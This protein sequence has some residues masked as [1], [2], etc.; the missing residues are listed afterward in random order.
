M[1]LTLEEEF[2]SLNMI[3]FHQYGESFSNDL[4]IAHDSVWAWVRL[5]LTMCTIPTDSLLG[6]TPPSVPSEPPWG[7]IGAI[8]LVIQ[9]SLWGLNT[10]EWFDSP[11][12]STP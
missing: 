12:V 9:T 10:P 4:K 8:T 11:I 3:R 7:Q 5:A 1:Q 6:A 2:Y